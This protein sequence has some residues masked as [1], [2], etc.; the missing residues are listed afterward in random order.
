M[1]YVAPDNWEKC[2]NPIQYEVVKGGIQALSEELARQGSALK[3]NVNCIIPGFIRRFRQPEIQKNSDMPDMDD[4][5][6][7]EIG[8]VSDISNVVLFLAGEAARYITG[9]SIRVSGGMG[10]YPVGPR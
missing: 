3:V 5:P 10:L 1:I 4:I 6:M 7:H 8:E 2:K 9:Q